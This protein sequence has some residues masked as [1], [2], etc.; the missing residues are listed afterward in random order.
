METQNNETFKQKIGRL[1]RESDK[2]P[3]CVSCA[4]SKMA[5]LDAVD[6]MIEWVITTYRRISKKS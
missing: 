6:N 3:G 5:T 1:I 4:G 2:T